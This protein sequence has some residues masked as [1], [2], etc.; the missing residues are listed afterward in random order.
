[1]ERWSL[2][3]RGVSLGVG[4]EVSKAHTRPSL[5]FSSSFLW[6]RCELSETA[7]EQRLSASTMLPTINGQGPTL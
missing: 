2:A 1:M 7:T 4:F 5:S 6:I 3:G